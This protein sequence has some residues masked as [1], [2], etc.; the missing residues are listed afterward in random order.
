[1]TEFW[2]IG[3][4]LAVALQTFWLRLYQSVKCEYLLPFLI[5]FLCWIWPRSRDGIADDNSC[6]LHFLLE[7]FYFWFTDAK[8]L[9]IQPKNL[10]YL[11]SF[12]N[13]ITFIAVT[14]STCAVCLE[15]LLRVL[16]FQCPHES[17]TQWWFCF[18]SL[19]FIYLL[20]ASNAFKFFKLFTW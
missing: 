12:V 9:W 14:N 6:K 1:M 3:V 11:V 15:P 10:C 4:L 19:T 2:E 16:H 18:T 7:I 5:N 17:Y 20:L 8:M 13:N